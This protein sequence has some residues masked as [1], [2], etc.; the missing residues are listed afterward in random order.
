M[1][2]RQTSAEF[3]AAAGTKNRAEMKSLVERRKTPGLLAYVDGEPV[4]WVS[5]APRAQFGRIERSPLF[6]NRDGDESSKEM[7]SITCF[8][9]HRNHRGKG[10][11]SALVTSAVDF[12]CRKGARVVEGYP[13]DPAHKAKWSS[14]D[15]Y[16]GTLDMFLAA[17]FEEVER[18]KPLRP[19]VRYYVT[20]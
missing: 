11:A 4:G 18:R 19:L 16:I 12:A 20:D 13:L 10:I 2:H 9:I 7:W 8:F 1:F 14:A 3:Q 6:K 5:I 17:G 15:A